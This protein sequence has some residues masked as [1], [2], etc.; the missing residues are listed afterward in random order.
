[1][2]LQD[3]VNEFYDIREPMPQWRIIS[4]LTEE[5][6]EVQ[7]AFNKWQDGNKRKP[8]AEKD[9]IEE[10][11]Q[12][13]GC[14]FVAARNYGLNVEDLMLEATC[15]LREKVAQIRADGWS[16]DDQLG[17]GQEAYPDPR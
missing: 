11:V 16:P 1:M 3:A 15:F 17:Y 10:L 5:A 14:C 12:L 7:G 9:V 2:G 8:K 6:G 13:T 4:M